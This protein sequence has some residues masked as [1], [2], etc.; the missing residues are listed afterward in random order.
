MVHGCRTGDEIAER[1]P[2][3]DGETASQIIDHPGDV[4]GE[5]GEGDTT[6]RSART[7]DA[8]RLRTQHPVTGADECAGQRVEVRAGVASVGRDDDDGR[9]VPV[10]AGVER[11]PP[12][13]DDVP[14][15][16]FASL[17]GSVVA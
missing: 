5:V 11:H 8:A 3:N 7:G 15:H 9:P 13:G 2:E 12:A 1:V 16:A 17:T 6:H 14:G 4:V 10:D